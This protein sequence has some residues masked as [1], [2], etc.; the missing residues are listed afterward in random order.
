MTVHANI[1]E[2]NNFLSLCLVQVPPGAFLLPGHF[3]ILLEKVKLLKGQS[4]FLG[5]MTDGRD[6]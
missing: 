3:P 2:C 5:W 1:I 4:Q 6:K